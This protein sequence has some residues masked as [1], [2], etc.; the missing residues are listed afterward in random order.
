MRQGIINSTEIYVTVKL[1]KMTLQTVLLL[2]LATV[3]QCT[4]EGCVLVVIE[5]QDSM[6]CMKKQIYSFK[7]KTF[8]ALEASD[9]L[10]QA[11]KALE[12][13]SVSSENRGS[14]P[15]WFSSLKITRS[16]SSSVSALTEF[17]MYRSIWS[18]DPRLITNNVQ[19]L[20]YHNVSL[21]TEKKNKK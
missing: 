10:K 21:H 18:H 16:S 2:K 3:F 15:F 11:A 14:P 13:Q 19:H 17:N 20:E 1:T 5:A 9:R 6:M 4:I 8:Y 7:S 12:E